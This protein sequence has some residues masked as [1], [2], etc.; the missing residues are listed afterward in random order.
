MFATIYIHQSG[1]ANSSPQLQCKLN[2]M[3]PYLHL[4]ISAQ[5][6][7]R[8]NFSI[9]LP[10]QMEIKLRYG[11]VDILASILRDET[12]FLGHLK[13]SSCLADSR[14]EC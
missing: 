2:N 7:N 1:S 9:A 6:R 11:N 4:S 14:D 10:C 8:A 12:V 13:L 5:L 3:V